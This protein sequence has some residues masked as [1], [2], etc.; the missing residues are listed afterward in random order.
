MFK[1]L[2]SNQL[3]TKLRNLDWLL[4]FIVL[5][6]G[7][8]SLLTIYSIDTGQNNYFEKHTIRFLF[9]FILL[10]AVALTSIKFWVGSA[11]LFYIFVLI[12]LILV[13]YFG[14]SA[15]GAKRWL[16]LGV[17]NLQ[18]SELMKVAVILA[19][20]RYYQFIKIDDTDRITKL[21]LPL[22]L[23]I[24]PFIVVVKQP[25]LGTALFILAVSLAMLWLAG[26]NLRIFSFGA[27]SV[28]ILAP[29]SI[30]LLKPYQKQRILTF[31]NPEN[32]PLGAGYHV[33]QSKI[34]IGSGGFFGKG[35]MKGSQSNL[36]FLPEKHTDFIFTVFAEQ[37]G[38]IG[39]ILLILLFIFLIMRIDI[40]SKNSR[41]TFSRLMC[42]GISFNFF[43][44]VGIN[45]GM[46]S[47][48]LPIVGVPIPIMSY[49]GTAMITTMFALGLVL[50][51]HIHKEENIY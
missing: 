17:F 20:A 35:F 25:D 42:F 9:S 30:S 21:A 6:I 41:N 33:I 13:D 3:N 51:A 39:C 14:L 37:F 18:P 49:G 7:T 5:L 28:L 46:V 22:A 48:L 38:Y 47:G 27:I 34:A 8:I 31:F 1:I 19:L 29:L 2:K 26:L 24:I 32:D 50:S 45:I 36:D 40:I 16:N 4:I 44:Y 11:Y 23:I 10:I 12:L 43:V 15:Q